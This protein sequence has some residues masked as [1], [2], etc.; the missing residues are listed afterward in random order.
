VEKHHH[1]ERKK[2]VETVAIETPEG[3]LARVG[4]LVRGWGRKSARVVKKTGR[5]FVRAAN[6]VAGTAAAEF[7]IRNAKTATKAVGRGL[8]FLSKPLLWAGGTI[9]ASS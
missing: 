9:I 4:N 8:K 5:W 6:W 3:L 1:I 2:T 7:V